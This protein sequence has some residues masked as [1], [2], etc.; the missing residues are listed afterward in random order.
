MEQL[1]KITILSSIFVRGE[2]F[3][4]GEEVEVNPREAKELIARGIATDETDISVEEDNLQTLEEMTKKELLSYAEQ[5]GIE[6][7]DRLNK[8]EIIDLINSD[9]DEQN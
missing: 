9:E 2:M 7:S 8:Q 5:L 4:E 6:A 3:K 1:V